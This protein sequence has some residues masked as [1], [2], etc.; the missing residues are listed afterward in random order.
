MTGRSDTPRLVVGLVGLGYRPH[1]TASDKNF[2]RDL[3]HALAEEGRCRPLVLGLGG[4]RTTGWDE[5]PSSAVAF[6]IVPRPL[7]RTPQRDTEPV[8]HKHGPVREYVE[9]TASLAPVL[10]WVLRHKRTDGMSHVHLFDN[11]GPATPFAFAASGVTHSVSLFSST[12]LSDDPRRRALWLSSLRGAT[13]V[14]V[15]NEAL[16]SALRAAGLRRVE[17]VPWTT[18]GRRDTLLRQ[19]GN[20]ERVV[21]SGPLQGTTEAEVERAADVLR[22][23]GCDPGID[24]EMWPKPEHAEW[25]SAI[26]AAH[27][28]PVRVVETPFPGALRDAS[29]LVSP[30]LREGAVVAP[31]LT[32]I[33]AVDE[34]CIVVTTDCGGIPADLLDSGWVTA[35]RSPDPSSLA[36]VVLEA[37]R[38]RKH[39]GDPPRTSI[40]DVS[41][42]Y[43]GVWERGQVPRARRVLRG[44]RGGV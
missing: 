12:G 43:E 42:A 4:P 9:R 31:P 34:G 44:E 24:A 26:A 6:E 11:L 37:L 1:R 8:H 3:A 2:M 27:R 13:S 17:V 35:S 7:H 19:P 39:L 25:V 38:R 22:R 10:S 30:V 41:R 21:W 33:E 5:G 36:Q 28:V 15:P 16:R 23:C 14:I 18:R 29:V 20:A 40:R 32:W